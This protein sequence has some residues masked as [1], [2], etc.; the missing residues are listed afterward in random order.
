MNKSV[1]IFMEGVGKLGLT[2]RQVAA[3]GKITKVCLEGA[4]LGGTGPYYVSYLIQDDDSIKDIDGMVDNGDIRGAIAKYGN[5]I[6]PND[7]SSVSDTVPFIDEGTDITIGT[8]GGVTL[9]RNSKLFGA[10]MIYRE[11]NPAETTK[12]V[13]DDDPAVMEGVEPSHDHN[14]PSKVDDD[15]IDEMYN[16][17]VNLG[18]SPDAINLVASINGYSEETMLDILYA[19]FGY[20]DFEQLDDDPTF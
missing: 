2:D 20:R 11:L 12:V 4:N 3:I 13:K 18:V 17:L 1:K 16:R 9:V 14:N 10:Y 8:S 5:L 7:E 6:D 19:E 15:A